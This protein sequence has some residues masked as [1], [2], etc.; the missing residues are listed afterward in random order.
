MFAM[1]KKERTFA[2][3]KKRYCGENISTEVFYGIKRI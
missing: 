3:V 2:F 1:I